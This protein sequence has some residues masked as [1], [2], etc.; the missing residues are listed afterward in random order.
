MY[1][2]YDNVETILREFYDVRMKFY[3]KRKAYLL[4]QFQ[5]ETDK[6]SNQARFI[7]EKCDGVLTVE[8]KKRKL[9]V[10]E[11]KKRGVLFRALLSVV[12]IFS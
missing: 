1:C 12:K 2:R 3:I 4:G 5:A 8:N 10:E 9:L 6:I 11:L 7:V